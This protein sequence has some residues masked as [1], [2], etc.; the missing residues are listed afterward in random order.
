MFVPWRKACPLTSV[1][2]L[3]IGESSQ[4]RPVKSLSFCIAVLGVGVQVLAAVSLKR[5]SLWGVV[6]SRPSHMLDTTDC[7]GPTT[8][9]IWAPSQSSGAS[10]KMY[11]RKN[12]KNTEQREGK[13]IK[14]EYETTVWTPRWEKKDGVGGGLDIGAEICLQPVERPWW[15]RCILPEVNSA[16]GGPYSKAHFPDRNCSHGEDLQW[17]RGKVWGWRSSREEPLQT[18]LNSPF[19]SPPVTLGGRVGRGVEK[20]GVKLSLGKKRWGGGKVF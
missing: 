6:R 13:W 14:R 15:S 19:P 7:N 20:E 18:E 8:G 16:C 9:H 2:F 3:W 17:S 1:T 10:G 12:K 5:L 11:L 4:Q